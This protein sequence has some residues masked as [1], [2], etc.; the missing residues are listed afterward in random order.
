MGNLAGSIK[1]QKTAL[2][3]LATIMSIRMLGLFMILPV[4]ST[5]AAKFSNATPE[6]I[7]LTLGIYGLTQALFQ[8]PLGMLSDHIGRKPVILGGLLL[9]LIGSVIAA[10]AHTMS[11]LLLGRALQGSGAIGS[12]VLA[13]TAD[14]TKEASRSK[15]MALMGLAIGFAF[16][17]ALILGPIL[18]GLFGLSGIFWTTSILAIFAMVLLVNVIP[19]TSI[20][21]T[22]IQNDTIFQ[23]LKVVLKNKDLLTFNFGIFSLHAILTA[24]FL[25]LPMIL[26]HTINLSEWHQ[27]D[28][29]LSVL[30]FSFL[31][32][33]PFIM[34]AEKKNLTQSFFLGAITMIIIIEFLFSLFHHS[35]IAIAFLLLVFFTAFTFLEANLPSLVSKI[36]PAHL[37]GTA[38]GVYSSCQFFGIFIGGALGGLILKKADFSGVF[39]FSAFLG[40]TWFLVAFLKNT[41]L[42][43]F[44]RPGSLPPLFTEK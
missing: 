2:I 3:A 11:I 31:F 38:M 19:N 17:L 21:L 13:L 25:I 32:A 23:R 12:T 42:R 1:S 4:F 8:M 15:A 6:L 14:L 5:A 26:L 43:K 27:V 33:L 10:R 39:L 36:A 22:K 35:F 28:L 24:L 30:F 7:G 34:I 20:L 16:T 44:T 37:K 29:Y 9:L 41:G 18:N 40:L